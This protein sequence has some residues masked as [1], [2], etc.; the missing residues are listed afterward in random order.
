MNIELHGPEYSE[1]H[2]VYT[3]THTVLYVHILY[4][5]YTHCIVC[6]HT[7]L[8]V[9]TLYCMYTVLH[10]HT[11]YCMYTH[12]TVCIHTVLYVQ[13]LYCMY[14]HCTVCTHTVLYVHTLYC[15]YIHYRST[16]TYPLKSLISSTLLNNANTSSSD[17]C[18]VSILSTTGVSYPYGN[19]SVAMVMC[20]IWQQNKCYVS[21]SKRIVCKS[22]NISI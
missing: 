22:N 16:Y 18:S 10:V 9:H 7:V 3:C 21:T 13:T 15:M 1:L 8:Y 14:T 6:T 11:L 2:T 4:C 17:I 20:V 12:C 19:T 5:M